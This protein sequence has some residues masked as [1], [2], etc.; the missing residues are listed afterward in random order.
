MTG[1]AHAKNIALQS[2]HHP[3]VS[4]E[5]ET[6]EELALWLVQNKAYA[7]A[8]S[9]AAGGRALDVGC[10]V[11]Y[12][13]DIIARGG[14]EV[15]GVDV[16]TR[17]LAEATARYAR[18]GLS[19]QAVDG[20]VLPFE[21]DSFDVVSSFQVIE[22]LDDLSAYL[23]E[24]A[25]VVKPGGSVLFTTPNR[26]IRLDPG[27]KPWNKF[28][29][30]EF[31]SESLGALLKPYFAE[32]KIRGLF[33]EPALYEI[34]Y[35]RSQRMLRLARRKYLAAV[36]GWIVRTLPGGLVVKLEGLLRRLLNATGKGAS[37]L[38]EA[39]LS[40]WSLDDLYYGTDELETCLDFMAVCTGKTAKSAGRDDVQAA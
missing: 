26:D 22:H 5:P 8:A 24:I 1:T 9:I 29:V 2:D 18:D 38:S 11:G 27:M 35:Q 39:D 33:A 30:T 28:H 36:H 25:R 4:T 6:R 31:T 13:S 16:S 19:F 3:I 12:G 15:T 23:G 34:E 14:A 21:D 37:P 40:R 32:V 10:N 20:N 7:E 17:A